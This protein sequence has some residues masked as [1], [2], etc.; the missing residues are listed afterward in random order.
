[1]ALTG[2]C[3]AGPA[4][5]AARSATLA[6]E[7]PVA[8]LRAEVIDIHPHD[9]EAFTEGLALVGDRLFESTGLAG[10][11]TVREVDLSSGTVRRQAALPA[12]WFG[13]GLAAV[14]DELFQLTWKDGR[15]LV[16]S[17]DDLVERR[18]LNLQGEGWGLCYDQPSG[19]LVVSDGSDRLIWRDPQTFAVTKTLQ[20]TR[21]GQPLDQLNE[22][23]CAADGVWANVWHRTDV[24]RIDPQSGR[25][26]AVADLSA[27]LPKGLG[28]EDVANGIAQRSDGTW[29]ITGKRWPTLYV[30]RFTAT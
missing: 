10:A 8:Q 9:P 11:S 19:Q 21:L 29:L 13:E 24:V 12:S 20:V 7:G 14:G 17:Q 6:P 25:V 15:V 22:L 2:A 26:T 16:W 30:V 28:P 27:L 18:R 3:G 4:K 23:E 1:M 5:P